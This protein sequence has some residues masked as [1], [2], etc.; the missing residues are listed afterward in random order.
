MHEHDLVAQARSMPC[1]QSDFQCARRCGKTLE[2][3]NHVCE[4]GCHAGPCGPCPSAG[5]RTCPCG[6]ETYDGLAC[7]EKAPSC[8]GTCDKLLPCG[9]HRCQER[10]VARVNVGALLS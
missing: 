8:G 4:A 10:C 5:K 9:L 7:T 1:N 2:C 6:K 3:G